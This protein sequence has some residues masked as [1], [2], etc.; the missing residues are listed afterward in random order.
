MKLLLEKI[1]DINVKAIDD[2]TPL[3]LALKQVHIE[4]VKLLIERVDDVNYKDCDGNAALIIASEKGYKEIIV[5]LLE[6]GS[7]YI[8]YKTYL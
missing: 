6:K 5:L 7:S 8:L 2:N 4:I 1:A 3:I